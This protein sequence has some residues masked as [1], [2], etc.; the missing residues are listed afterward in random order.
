MTKTRIGLS[1]I[2]G[3]GLVLAASACADMQRQQD[4]S[5]RNDYD[6]SL[7]ELRSTAERGD[8]KAQVNLGVIYALGFGVPQNHQEASKWFRRAA[9]QGDER[10]QT[11]LGQMYFH[12][13]GVPANS[14]QAYMWVTLAVAQGDKEAVKLQ[15]EIATQ[16]TPDQITEAQRLA[17]EWK[18]KGK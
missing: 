18:P 13:V 2:A 11:N 10:A 4:G 8:M 14:I 1:I 5:Q 16:M 15:D 17:R 3:L 12:G 9:E 6:T 7:K